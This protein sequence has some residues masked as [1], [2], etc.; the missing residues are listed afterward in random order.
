[1]STIIKRG[2]DNMKRKI[3]MLVNVFLFFLFFSPLT[4]AEQEKII[5][6]TFD[7]TYQ[8][9]KLYKSDFN[10]EKSETSSN[11]LYDEKG[12]CI[13]VIFG[14]DD[15]IV[16]SEEQYTQY[17]YRAIC[18]IEVQYNEESG[19]IYP[20]TGFLVGPSTILT[21][22]HTVYH[23]TYGWF[24]SITFK[25]GS[26]N[27]NGVYSYEYITS[28]WVQA[29]CG[30]FF[31]TNS[32]NDDWAIIDIGPQIGSEIGYLGVSANLS[33]N[34]GVKLYGY[35]DDL[36]GN[37]SYGTGNVT[38]LETYRF[39]HNCDTV[40]GSSGGPITYGSSAVGIQ[41]SIFTDGSNAI[42]CKISNYIVS[43]IDERL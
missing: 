33:S 18:K 20:A 40:I 27:N 37:M 9:R 42:A 32:V 43:W 26:R 13:G 7:T 38:H 6:V 34:N 35:H 11:I 16:L 17:P 31:D 21:A 28:S 4:F 8:Q 5:G 14:N 19:L 15:R 30:S 12:N 29:T 3:I 1:M 24:D 41:S 39:F 25:F 10:L 22:C 36:L 23:K 2:G